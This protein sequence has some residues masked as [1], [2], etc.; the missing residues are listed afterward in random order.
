MQLLWLIG[1]YKVGVQHGNNKSSDA[2]AGPHRSDLGHLG[3]IMEH[4]RSNHD[5]QMQQSTSYDIH[6]LLLE[7]HYLILIYLAKCLDGTGSGDGD[8][9][10]GLCLVSS[11]PR[12]FR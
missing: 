6:S 10:L 4:L 5:M 1:M 2:A 12:S 8:L 3:A 9:G 7:S 11:D